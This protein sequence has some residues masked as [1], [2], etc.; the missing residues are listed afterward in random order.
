MR[1]TRRHTPAI[2]GWL[3]WRRAV[4]TL[5]KREALCGAAA[6]ERRVKLKAQ[7]VEKPGEPGRVE[8]L[9]IEGKG[10]LGLGF[11]V[12]LGLGYG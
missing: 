1:E 11:A 2:E 8:H 5:C 3:A 10:K 9:V 4:P 7:G 6:W 12:G